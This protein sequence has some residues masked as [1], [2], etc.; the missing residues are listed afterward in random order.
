MSAT[1]QLLSYEGSITFDK[2]EQI[3]TLFS[4]RMPETNCP[5]C[6]IRMFSI[7][8]ECLENAYRH[9]FN[10]PEQ[11]PQISLELTQENNHY[12]LTIGNRASNNDLEKLTN[13]IDQ[14]NKLSL[15]DIKALYNETI[16]AGHITE[17]GGAGLGLLKILRCSREPIIY[18]ITAIDKESS[19]V[20][21]SISITD[22]E[23]Q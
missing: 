10:T 13:N 8:V 18:T 5:V 20:N 14:F 3:L 9:N 15:A 19:F 2:I 23:K 11:N 21:L 22:P 12:K 4:Q 16:H 7:M 17:K 1:T 6:K